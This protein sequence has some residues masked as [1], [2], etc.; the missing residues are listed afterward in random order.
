MVHR[1]R[2]NN[3]M[4]A[5]SDLR[6]V[7][8]WKIFRPDSVIADVIRIGNAI[9][10]A[11]FFGGNIGRSDP[12]CMDVSRLLSSQAIFAQTGGGETRKKI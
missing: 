10:T 12:N 1:T 6:V 7:L 3:A 9:Q 5:K 2:D 4:H 11:N 8:K